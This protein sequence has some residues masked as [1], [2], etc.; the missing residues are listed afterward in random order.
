MKASRRQ[1]LRANELALTLEQLRDFARSYGNYLAIGAV[2]VAAIVLV[3][4]FRQRSASEARTTAVKMMGSL[5]SSTDT[6]ARDSINQLEDLLAETSDPDWAVQTLRRQAQVAMSRAK[7]AD[8][9]TPSAEFLSMAKKAYR[10]MLDRGAG[11]T[12]HLGAALCGLA[13]VEEDEFILDGDAVHKEAARGYLQRIRDDAQFNGTP[14]QSLVLER[15]NQLDATFT[16]ITLAPAPPPAALTPL[17]TED[18][19]PPLRG[20]VVTF[21]EEPATETGPPVPEAAAPESPA[22]EAP[23]EDEPAPAEPQSSGD[24]E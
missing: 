2:V 11:R 5:T 22:D 16:V 12:L 24:P 14:F 1:E 4:I 18:L 10:Q 19:P 21:P 6:E 23:V 20:D 9:G 3:W 17:P 7:A 8:D 13:T 15:L